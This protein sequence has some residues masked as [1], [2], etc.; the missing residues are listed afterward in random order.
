MK[1]WFLWL[2]AGIVSVIGGVLA[3]SNP[4]AASITASLLA[5]WIFMLV[6]VMM[7]ASAF[8][9]KGWGARILAILMGLAIVLIGFSLVAHPLIGVFSLTLAVGIFL[10]VAGV[11]RIFVGLRSEFREFRW[12]MIL[13]AV[14]SI[15]LAVMILTNFPQSALVVLGIYLGIELI[16]TGV[17]L[18]AISLTRKKQEEPVT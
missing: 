15:V 1:N 2:L 10:L 7:I 16:S 18:I 14:V 3:L 13:S 8:G 5:G 12:V 4:F 9:D 17:S 6:G 11:I